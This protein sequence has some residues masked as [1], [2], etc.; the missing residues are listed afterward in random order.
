MLTYKINAT[1]KEI[2]SMFPEL[3]YKEKDASFIEVVHNNIFTD[4]INRR[5]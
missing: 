2:T 4:K 3:Y 5:K 1:S